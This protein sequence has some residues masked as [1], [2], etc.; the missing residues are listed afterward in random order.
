MRQEVT[1]P[2][3]NRDLDEEDLPLVAVFYSDKLKHARVRIES[4]QEQPGFSGRM[5]RKPGTGFDVLFRVHRAYVRNSKVLKLMMAHPMYRHTS[6]WDVDEEDPTG[7]WRAM[8]I[9]KEVEVVETRL[10][11]KATEKPELPNLSGIQSKVRAWERALEAKE[12]ANGGDSTDSPG[13]DGEDRLHQP[14]AKG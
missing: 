10:N 1:F 12:V 9:V 5:E 2:T 6:G 4:V 11:L 13:T 7:F 8:G 14:S 3:M